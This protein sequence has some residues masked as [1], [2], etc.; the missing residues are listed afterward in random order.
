MDN[1]KKIAIW[2]VNIALFIAVVYMGINQAG[3][4]A[5]ISLLEDQTESL[6]EEKHNLS[7][8]ILLGNSTTSVSEKSEKLG[9]V[10]PQDVVYIDSEELFAAL[11][12]R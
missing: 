9:F 10:K 11:I 1:T 8:K 12:V 2:A 5:E 6:I 4:G 7:E 3:L